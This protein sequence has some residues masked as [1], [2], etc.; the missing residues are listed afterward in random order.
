MDNIFDL[1]ADFYAQDEEWN[2]VLQ[3]S[4][5]ENFLRTKLWQGASEE[6]LYQ[7]WDHITVLCIF[8]GNSDNYLGDM[9]KEDFIDCVGWCA[10]NVSDFFV[11]YEQ[12][13]SFFATM[14]EL[15]AHLKKK[16]IIG[17]KIALFY[18]FYLCSFS[19]LGGRG[20]EATVLLD[21]YVFKQKTCEARNRLLKAQQYDLNHKNAIIIKEHYIIVCA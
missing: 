6:E 16:R 18:L 1:V 8:L 21:Q 12:I 20:A 11:T 2:T 17:E 14:T 19:N 10:R 15:Y 4:Y 7:A 13:D 5:V 9:S 3:Q